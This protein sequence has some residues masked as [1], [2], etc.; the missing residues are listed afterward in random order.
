M[1]L[2]LKNQS[3]I[4][5]FCHKSEIKEFELDEMIIAN[6]MLDPNILNFIHRNRETILTDEN[7]NWLYDELT[8]LGI[9]IAEKGKRFLNEKERDY[10]LNYFKKDNQ[11]LIEYFIP[12]GQKQLVPYFGL[13][14]DLS[15]GE[16][17]TEKENKLQ[18]IE[19]TLAATIA[20]LCESGKFK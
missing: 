5:D 16:K 15:A 4:S 1:N 10:I 11:N 2:C 6:P 20:L 3:I 8:R 17:P 7:D 12:D 19:A 18:E 14:R 9:G 13:D